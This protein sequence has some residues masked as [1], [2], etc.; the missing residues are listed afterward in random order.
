MNIAVQIMSNNNKR[1]QLFNVFRHVRKEGG[2]EGAES[3]DWSMGVL[4]LFI[5]AY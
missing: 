3:M 1:E 2:R 4:Q 5:S